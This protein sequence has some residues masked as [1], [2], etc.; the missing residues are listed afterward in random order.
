VT[1]GYQSGMHLDSDFA[2]MAID[3]TFL[4]WEGG[5]LYQLRR[6]GYGALLDLREIKLM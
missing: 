3:S 4:T 2:S 1:E 6:P 5:K